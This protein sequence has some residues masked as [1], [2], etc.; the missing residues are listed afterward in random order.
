MNQMGTYLQSIKFWGNSAWE[1]LVAAT[2]FFLGL[3]ILKAF[4]L[5]ILNKLEALSKKT[6]TDWDDAAIG[7]VRSIKPSL[8]VVLSAYI[9][10]R[11]LA[12][13]D[14]MQGW[15]DVLFGAVVL[16]F[17][18]KLIGQ[19]L[20]FLIKKKVNTE[21]K[22]GEDR[23]TTVSLY[24]ML[25][26]VFMAVLWSIA[27]L[28]LLSNAGIDVTSIIASLGI[29]GIA[30]ALA[31]QNILSDMFSSFSILLDKPFK[32]GDLI[33]LG[34]DSGTVEKIG[35]KTTRLRTLQG[36]ELIISNKELTG[37]RIENF[38]RMKKRRVVTTLGVVYGLSAEVLRSIPGIVEE[39]VTG[40]DNVSFDRCHLD[41]FGD[42]SINFELV[43]FI[44]SG[45][46]A[47]YMER[48]QEINL[49]IYD[50][51]AAKDIGFAYP[52]QVVQIEQSEKN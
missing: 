15:I 19:F 31:L 33:V 20:D 48:K 25:R 14:D 47:M 35:L 52:T 50:A 30:I 3:L 27:I 8:Y 37:A 1:Y 34:D 28:M 43:Y 5:V 51:F 39:I 42:F 46:Y 18:V 11:F 12:F 45:D 2:V 7:M 32:V 21:V 36:Q 26:L 29:G 10:V 4:Q 49:A 40:I 24:R 13:S 6:S 38:K 16:F 44:D 9:A 41:V 22:K 23:G 17:V